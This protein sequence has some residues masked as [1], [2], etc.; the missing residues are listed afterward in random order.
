[1]VDVAAA[2]ATIIWGASYKFQMHEKDG[3][4]CVNNW[5][6]FTYALHICTYTTHTYIPHLHTLYSKREED[7]KLLFIM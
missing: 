5:V 2:A 1:M 3:G 6:L 7:F 4:V